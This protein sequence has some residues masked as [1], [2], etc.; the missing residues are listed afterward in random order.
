MSEPRDFTLDDFHK[1]L[2]TVRER[3]C[4]D[5][6]ADMLGF[7]DTIESKE[8]RGAALA[9]LIRIFEAVT[10]E[11]RRDPT[12]I[13][14]PAMRR[15]AE[16]AGTEPHEVE[17]LLRQCAFMREVLRRMHNASIW[18]RIKLTLGLTRFPPLA[19]GEGPAAT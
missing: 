3:G 10:L 2:V 12:R 4:D 9:R 6:T 16:T 8:Q 1:Y 17:R 11:E 13:D 7:D 19:G 18:E 5:L 15:I 14:G